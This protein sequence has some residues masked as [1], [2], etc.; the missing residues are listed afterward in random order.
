MG[1]LLKCSMGCLEL[2]VL[3]LVLYFNLQFFLQNIVLIRDSE[4]PRKFYPR[5]N[6]ED[7]SSFKDLDDHRYLRSFYFGKRDYF[8]PICVP[9]REIYPWPELKST[10]FCVCVCMFISSSFWSS[11]LG[12]TK[13]YFPAFFFQLSLDTTKIA[14]YLPF[15]ASANVFWKDYTMTTISIGKRIFGGKMLWRPCPS[16]WTHRRC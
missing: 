5:F 1:T 9:D 8:L 10:E 7:T 11:I 6:I 14:A 3:V 12:A 13:N 4:D 16:C 15:H 2:P